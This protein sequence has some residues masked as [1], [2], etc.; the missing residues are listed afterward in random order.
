MSSDIR[1]DDVQDHASMQEVSRTGGDLHDTPQGS[2]NSADRTEN[3]QSSAPHITPAET[4]EPQ[5]LTV[6]GSPPTRARKRGPGIF[7]LPRQS[8]S[9]PAGVP[10][11]TCI[12]FSTPALLT[13]HF[14]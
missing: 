3:P 14:S 13:S 1:D 10:T 6:E 12:S 9:T 2:E 4:Q 8:N 5:P 7:G 11:G